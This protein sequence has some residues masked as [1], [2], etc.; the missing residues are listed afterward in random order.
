MARSTKSRTARPFAFMK[1]GGHF[2]LANR[3]GNGR[4]R[5]CVVGT[6][7][8]G[9]I[10]ISARVH[11][12]RWI[13]GIAGLFLLVVLIFAAGPVR[14]CLNKSVRFC[15]S[16]GIPY[17]WITDQDMLARPETTLYYPGSQLLDR[18][19]TGYD[20][21]GVGG[22]LLPGAADARSVLAVDASSTSILNWYDGRLRT[23]GWSR[24]F[25]ASQSEPS[26]N[27][28]H[29][30]VRDGREV[31][32]L[33]VY[34]DGPPFGFTVGPPAGLGYRGSGTTYEFSYQVFATTQT[35]PSPY[36]CP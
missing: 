33:Q 19:V 10:R 8:T 31:L 14:L 35:R 4:A 21:N 12:G 3:P 23:R 7:L 15:N 30:Y 9:L 34:V 22:R 36:G 6:E 16:D 26:P 28:Q 17:G 18:N 5:R 25:C 32:S 29:S 20:E 11:V 27:V 13:L 24:F 2:G 1:A